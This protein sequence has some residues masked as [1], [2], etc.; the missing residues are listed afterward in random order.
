[1]R[2]GISRTKLARFVADKLEA[3]HQEV[4]R[5]LAAYLIDSRRTRE[6]ELIIREINEQF[7]RR[8]IVIAEVATTRPLDAA[9]RDEIKTLLDAKEVELTETI[10]P[11]LLGGIRLTTPSRELD[12]TIARRL[13]LLRDYNA[14]TR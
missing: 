9:L 3:G 13:K 2:P 6:T 11:T 10:D 8:G 1:M 5:E 4:I 7:E 14:L 12:A